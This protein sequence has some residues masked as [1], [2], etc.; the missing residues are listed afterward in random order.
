MTE[1]VFLSASALNEKSEKLQPPN[2]VGKQTG[3]G[4][5]KGLIQDLIP[6]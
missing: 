1:K 2:S 6:E 5:F 4:Y 3:F